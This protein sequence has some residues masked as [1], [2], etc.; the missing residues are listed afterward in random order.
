MDLAK[1][2]AVL[3]YRVK[4]GS[5]PFELQQQGALIKSL[6]PED[7]L[8]KAKPNELIRELIPMINNL[9]STSI[10]ECKDTFL[11]SVKEFP[12]YGSAFFV[13]KQTTITNFPAT[14]IIAI[15]KRGIDFVDARSKLILQHYDFA[16]LS[17]WSS[18][19]TF[20]QASFGNMMGSKKLLCETSQGYKMDDLIA[21]YTNL[22]K[23]R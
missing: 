11:Q 19:N 14:M 20:F 6:I 17:F 9:K 4:Y 7:I 22:Y 13:V 1:K 15:N 5:S 2:L 3:I 18:G 23:M 10:D 8:A 21:S 12:T 16:D